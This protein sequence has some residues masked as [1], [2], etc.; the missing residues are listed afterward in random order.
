M[1]WN[2]SDQDF[3]NEWIECCK[4]LGSQIRLGAAPTVLL[5][6][7]VGGNATRA[8]NRVSRVS[9]CLEQHVIYVVLIKHMEMFLP[10]SGFDVV[11]VDDENVDTVSF[12]EI[13]PRLELALNYARDHDIPCL[14]CSLFLGGPPYEPPIPF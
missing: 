6:T 2:C 12:Q 7:F 10:D 1:S 5:Q 4:A 11:L 9:W 13:R 8:R 3:Y 14:P